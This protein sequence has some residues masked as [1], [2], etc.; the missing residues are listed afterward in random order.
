MS[1][2]VGRTERLSEALQAVYRSI[3][4][5]SINMVF[6]AL[7]AFVA[8]ATLVSLA[9]EDISM[10]RDS[11]SPQAFVEKRS[12]MESSRRTNVGELATC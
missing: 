7:A 6:I 3:M 4:S 8:A 10:D 9:S 1:C 2:T 5:Y 11:S 12:E